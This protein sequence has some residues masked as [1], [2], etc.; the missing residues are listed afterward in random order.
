MDSGKLTAGTY[1]ENSQ[2]CISARKR[3]KAMVG[4][5]ISVTVNVNDETF[6]LLPEKAGLRSDNKSNAKFQKVEHAMK[7]LIS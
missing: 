5:E 4:T 2:C 7:R 3:K 1:R 6:F